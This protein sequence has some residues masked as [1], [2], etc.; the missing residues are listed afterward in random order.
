MNGACSHL[1]KAG[2]ELIIMGFELTEKPIEP[3]AI[4]VDH[5]N[6]ILQDL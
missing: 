5:N 6:R 3:K 1:I 4:L 2:E